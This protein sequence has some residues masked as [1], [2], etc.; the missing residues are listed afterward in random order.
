MN[1][2]LMKSMAVLALAA[3]FMTGSASA[4]FGGR[5]TEAPADAP[6]VQDV[7][8]STYRG[9]AAEGRFSAGDAGGEAL[10]FAVES[11]PKKGS[12]EINGDSFTYT[13]KEGASG[14]DA[15]TY[16]ASNSAGST[17]LPA[18]VSITIEK[19]RS[20]VEYAD[21]DGSA[22]AGAAQHLAEAGIFTG[23]KI[24]EQYY[25]E[26][27]KT[28]SRSEFL[29]MALETA[30]RSVTSVTMTGFCDDGAIPT[31]AKAYAAAGVLDGVIQ[32]SVTP[33]GVA[34]RGGEAVTFN[35]AATILD[36]VLDLGDVDLEVWYAGQEAAPSWAS[37]AV[38][39]M[40]AVS[41]LSAGSFGSS[42]MDQAVT[43]A[44]AAQ[45]LSAARTLLD[46]QKSGGLFPWL[47]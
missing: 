28:V 6:V 29:A 15:F 38:A 30:G 27:D 17:S 7:E 26:P 40:E 18:R 35:E 20:G 11:G 19:T 46:G 12:V 33:E 42:A 45:M 25:F 8:L 5:K 24:G 32:G 3:A 41:V 21:M 34:F 43:R 31:W 2:R 4:L 14:K 22:A 39:N 44:G 47:G 37:Q 9:I 10:T 1:R 16:T 36:R 13:P 23:A